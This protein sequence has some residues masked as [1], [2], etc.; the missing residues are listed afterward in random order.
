MI[1]Q[2][3]LKEIITYDPETGICTW[4]TSPNKLL[5]IGREC[6]SIDVHGYYQLSAYKKIYKLH[7][8]C[9]LYMTGKMPDGQIDHINHNR[10][11]NRWCNLRV[12]DNKENHKN[13]PLQCNNKSG[14]P[15][16]CFS[17]KY[18]KYRSYITLSGKQIHLGLYE[19]INDAIEARK[20]AN[21]KYNFNK[22]HGV[23]IGI[24]KYKNIFNVSD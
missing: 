21:V 10:T 14:V 20:I 7:R 9:W 19:N 8:L 22:N 13:R 18:N 15:G 16:V 4:K 3:Q 5:P 17:S 6:K 11:D 24:K 2:E 23:G 1:T 12:V